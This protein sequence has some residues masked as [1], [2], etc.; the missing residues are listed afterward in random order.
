MLTKED[1]II[2]RNPLNTINPNFLRLWCFEQGENFN[3]LVKKVNSDPQ[4]GLLLIKQMNN[5]YGVMAVFK[6]GKL[7]KLI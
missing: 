4:E 6:D 5:Q 1:Y 3:D 7:I 2:A